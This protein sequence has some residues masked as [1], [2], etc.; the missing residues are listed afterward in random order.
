MFQQEFNAL[1]G[2]GFYSGSERQFCRKPRR[3]G[4]DVNF[5]E[6]KTK[7]IHIHFPEGA[8]PKDGPSAGVTMVSALVSELS[9]KPV[10]S[11]VAMTGEVTLRGK[12]LAIGGLKEK[13]MAAY[14]A[15]VKTVL[16][17]S[18]NVKDLE[19]IDAHVRE[20]L[21]FIPCKTVADV[22]KNAIVQ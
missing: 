15:G 4:V 17:P 5:I 13:T 8:V 10:R 14:K 1:H 2:I 6:Y 3:H 16:I 22:L 12:V 11:N 20:N 19:D 9:G 18:D 7:D 21:E